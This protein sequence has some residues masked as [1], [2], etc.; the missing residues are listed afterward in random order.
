VTDALS[1]KCPACGA[2]PG[3]K[4]GGIADSSKVFDKPHN[5]RVTAALA[6]PNDLELARL[7]RA[8]MLELQQS[9]LV[10]AN[11]NAA[12]K[13]LPDASASEQ[14]TGLALAVCRLADAHGCPREELIE[15]FAK[16]ARSF[17]VTTTVPE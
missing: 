6:L 15:A 8:E 14:V 2:K 5:M 1:V 10:E 11:A 12:L 7:K 16:V 3:E 13:S 17:P 4:C 9:Q